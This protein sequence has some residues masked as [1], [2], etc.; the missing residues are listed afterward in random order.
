M[1]RIFLT[2]LIFTMALFLTNEIE[3]Q[4]IT[5]R[6]F[7]QML[8]NNI[9]VVKDSILK[10]GVAIPDTGKLSTTQTDTVYGDVVFVGKVNRMRMMLGILTQ[11]STNA[12]THSAIFST[13]AGSITWTR[14]SVGSYTGTLVDGFATETFIFI[15]AIKSGQPIAFIQ[16]KRE[17]KDA[18]SVYTYDKEGVKADGLLY[19]QPILI[20][21]VGY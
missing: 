11:T 8:K 1:K 14:D 10:Y 19:Q 13:L 16:A 12:P 9:S 6:M 5:T 2:V 15:G 3:A 18:I 7:N 21:T 17:T 4:Q 20:Y